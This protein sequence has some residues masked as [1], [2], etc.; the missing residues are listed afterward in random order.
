[1]AA[2]MFKND[3]IHLHRFKTSRLLTSY[4]L[5]RTPKIYKERPVLKAGH[6]DY[7][8][9]TKQSLYQCFILSWRIN[10]MYKTIMS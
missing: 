9:E 3:S 7:F 2:V 1:M 4:E 5:L 6:I 8:Q 10:T